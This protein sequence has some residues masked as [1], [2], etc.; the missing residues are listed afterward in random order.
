MVRGVYTSENSYDFTNMPSDMRFKF[1]FDLKRWEEF[2]TYK[3]LPSDWDAGLN[4]SALK[5]I[6]SNMLPSEIQKMRE[7]ERYRMENEI[8]DLL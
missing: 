3:S 5:S 7:A 6:Q 2:F 1:S 8:D 4:Q